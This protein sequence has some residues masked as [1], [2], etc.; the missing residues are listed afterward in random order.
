MTARPAIVAVGD[1]VGVLLV[2]AVERLLGR[3][4][5]VVPAA[6]L[7]RQVEDRDD[8]HDVDQ[9][10]LDERDQGRGAQAGGVGVRR[11][12]RERDEQRQ[13]LGQERRVVTAADAHHLEHHL[14]A[15]ELQRDVGHGRQQA[16]DRD[17][18]RERLGAEAAPHEV[19]RR[20]VAV[21]VRDRPE[22]RQ[23]DEDDRVEHDRVGHGEEADRRAEV[24]RRRHRDEG[25]GGVD[26]AADQEP[27]DEGAEAAPAQ[28][29]LVEVVQ[30]VARAASGPRGSP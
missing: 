12:H 8:D 27:R 6:E 28:P 11:E 16:G 17:R 30:L 7:G 18:Q 10:V 15:D 21:P 23:E 24:Q 2:E 1:G 3:R 4:E 20:H 14:D 26:V 9:G 22:P 29:P 5:D 13:V 19:G 25:V